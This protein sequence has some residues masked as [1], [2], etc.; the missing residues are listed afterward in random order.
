MSD[1][2]SPADISEAYWKRKS[3]LLEGK[4]SNLFLNA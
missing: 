3:S 4:I 1:A 2:V